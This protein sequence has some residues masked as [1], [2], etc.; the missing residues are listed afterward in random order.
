MSVAEQDS[1]YTITPLTEVMGAEIVGLDVGQPFDADTL[2]T[3]RDAFQTHHV[4]CFRDQHLMLRFRV[5]ENAIKQ[6]APESGGGV[7]LSYST[8]DSSGL[9]PSF[10]QSRAWWFRRL[11]WDGYHPVE[12]RYHA[13]NHTEEY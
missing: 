10:R 4:L 1:G 6:S 8:R 7:L 11:R 5:Q 9:D 3:I 12:V 2:A 13:C